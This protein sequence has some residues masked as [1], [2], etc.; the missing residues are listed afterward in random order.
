MQTEEAPSTL[1]TIV[2]QKIIKTDEPTMTICVPKYVQTDIAESVV[3]GV[4]TDVAESA[5]M[6]V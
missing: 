3:A 2:P 4:Q 5:V 1:V 6:A